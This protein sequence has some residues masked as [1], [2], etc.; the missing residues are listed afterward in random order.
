[1]VLL[2]IL[3]DSETPTDCRCLSSPSPPSPGI[4]AMALDLA[5]PPMT[6][7]LSEWLPPSVAPTSAL[8]PS[9]PALPTL[10]AMDGS[11]DGDVPADPALCPPPSR[12]ST[13]PSSL[14]L[15]APL[16][17]DPASTAPS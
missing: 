12:E 1:V 5:S 8:P 13:S 17:G 16:A 14:T 15:S 11:L 2:P 3:L 4:P 9:L 7:L 10:V 6:S